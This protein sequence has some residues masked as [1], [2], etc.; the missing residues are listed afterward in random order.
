MAKAK[1][2]KKAVGKKSKGSG[3]VVKKTPAKQ[4]KKKPAVS[5]I[6]SVTVKSLGAGATATAEYDPVTGVLA[7][8]IPQGKQG[9]PGPAG[10]PGP[11]GEPGFQGPQGLRGEFGLRGETGQKGEPGKGI[12]FSLAPQDGVERTL[13]LDR[14][15]RLCFREGD[16]HFLIS[17]TPKI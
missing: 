15:G 8:G 3:K 9:P 13:Y 4:G 16:R 5:P 11:R 6:S 10:T 7:L 14:E 1:I 12:D 17:V 2:K